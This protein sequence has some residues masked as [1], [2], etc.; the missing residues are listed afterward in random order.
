MSLGKNSIP[1]GIVQE[2][3]IPRGNNNFVEQNI[4]QD[5]TIFVISAPEFPNTTGI[6]TFIQTDSNI[7]N[8][9]QVSQNIDQSMGNIP[10]FSTHFTDKD[11]DD[12]EKNDLV[13]DYS[14]FINND[15]VLDAVQFTNQ[16]IL[17]Q[18]NDNY[19]DNYSEQIIY[20]LSWYDEFGFDQ[21]SN[22]TDSLTFDDFLE[23]LSGE[24]ILDSVQF[25]VQDIR[26]F[27]R[28][29][30]ITQELEQTIA[31]F[32]TLDNDLVEELQ[33]DFS[34]LSPVQLVVQEDFVDTNSNQIE[35]NII[36]NIKF[37]FSFSNDPDRDVS[38]I[39][40]EELDANIDDL[41]KIDD[42]FIFPV[43]NDTIQDGGAFASQNNRQISDI[44]GDFNTD[45]KENNQLLVLS[46]TNEAVFTSLND[47]NLTVG[48]TNNFDGLKDLIFTG[49]G[50]D[51]VD[52]SE[53][54]A[55]LP[56]K[57]PT[58]NKVYAGSGND[59]IIA[60][61]GDRVFAGS[62]NDI[63]KVAPG[64]SN[65]R[66]YG[67]P[68]DDLFFLGD[69]GNNIVSGGKGKDVF[70]LINDRVPLQSNTIV[71]F[72]LKDDYLGIRGLGDSP[73][74]SFQSGDKN[75]TILMLDNSINIANFPGM[76]PS[77]LEQAR[78]IF[79]M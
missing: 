73:N 45:I 69:N 28:N 35:Q 63:L 53:S 51:T 39:T 74:L 57:I 15:N 10:L 25:A 22:F 26:I 52:F 79:E 62:G 64:G 46:E 24:Y 34:N 9:N 27:G 3:D 23:D 6:N 2:I 43:L 21:D 42:N 4:T 47:D 37:D 60:K 61:K 36:Q 71:G 72:D 7:G 76:Q 59:E 40:G 12:I 77:E 18:G 48:L 67:G 38:E 17:V 29:N 49:S 32:V 78:F 1:Q 16:Q 31:T 70:W 75:N 44:L 66:F 41:K 13:L 58:N 65:N 11:R 19:L 20:D 5:I 30:T 33:K 56:L 68:G 55:N 50:D 54:L 8:N 14:N